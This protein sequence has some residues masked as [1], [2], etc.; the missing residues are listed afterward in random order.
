MGCGCG[1][2][3]SRPA[4]VSRTVASTNGQTRTQA[5]KT[6]QSGT[7]KTALTGPVQGGRKTV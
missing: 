1:K 7:M 3:A 5:A 2:K 6:F 4:Q